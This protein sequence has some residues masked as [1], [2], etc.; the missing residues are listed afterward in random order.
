MNP[1]VYVFWHRPEVRDGYEQALAEF[2]AALW[3]A[4]HPFL[5]G[6]ASHRVSGLPW[7]DGDEGYE[8]CYL[9]DGFA[10][11]GALNEAAIAPGLRPDHDRVA[12]AA[13]WGAGGLY[14]VAQGSPAL[15]DPIVT[16]LSKP[17]GM[18]YEDFYSSL[19]AVPWLLRRQLVLGPA[20]EFCAA[21]EVAHGLVARRSLVCAHGLEV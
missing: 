14:Q 2:H 5:L 8:D 10:G 4:G 15:R 17:A 19:P 13:A 7:L 1:L 12:L 6:S 9:V 16:W 3:R 21:G 18:R 11:L 20:P